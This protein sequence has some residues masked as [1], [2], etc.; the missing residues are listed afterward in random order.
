MI[1]TRMISEVVGSPEEHVNKTIDLLLDRISE[2]KKIKIISEKKFEAKKMDTDP[3]F[4]GFIEYEA[5]FE[6][7]EHIIDFCFDFMP[8]S[9]EIIEPLNISISATAAAD[10][11]N[12]LLARLHQNDLLLRNIIAELKLIKQKESQ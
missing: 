1:V 9:I 2:Y 6:K 4:S 8:S 7:I 5:E 12:E 10:I 3:L 11:F